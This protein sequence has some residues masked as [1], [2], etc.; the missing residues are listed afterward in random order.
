MKKILPEFSDGTKKFSSECHVDQ[1]LPRILKHD[2]FEYCDFGIE[3]EITKFKPS[4]NYP[5]VI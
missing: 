5:T 3:K 4:I 2:S 1:D